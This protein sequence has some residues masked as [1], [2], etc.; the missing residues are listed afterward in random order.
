[1]HERIRP[2]SKIAHQGRGHADRSEYR[3]AAGLFDKA[4]GEMGF[5]LQI[6]IKVEAEVRFGS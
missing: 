2:A 6:A 5:S 4:V 1:L 3:K